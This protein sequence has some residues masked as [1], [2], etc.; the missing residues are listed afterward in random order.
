MTRIIIIILLTICQY[1]NSQ[2]MDAKKDIMEFYTSEEIGS[3]TQKAV[4]LV[5]QSPYKSSADKMSIAY[6]FKYDYDGSLQKKDFLDGSFFG[7]LRRSEQ[8][9]LMND[10][11]YIDANFLLEK[12]D[13]VIIGSGNAY[14]FYPEPSNH[15]K[16]LTI[17]QFILDKMKELRISHLFMINKLA[18]WPVFGVT[19]DNQVF[20]FDYSN[21]KPKVSSLNEF[22]KNRSNSVFE[23]WDVDNK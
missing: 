20:V 13:G 21:G 9:N 18:N 7:K 15:N 10:K 14:A 6:I 23:K 4:S 17:N 16:S 12:K 19:D 11:G 5:N 1:A 22:I 2:E 3:L 8:K